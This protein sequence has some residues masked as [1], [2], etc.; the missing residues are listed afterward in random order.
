MTLRH[1]KIFAAVCEH[2]GVT[3]A[4]EALHITQPAISRTIAELEKYYN[5]VLFE[6]INQRLVLTEVGR[7]V[8]GKAREIVKDFEGFEELALRGGNNPKVR[9]GCSL[10]L[11]QTVIPRF[12]KRLQEE[13]T[14]IEPSIVIKA[15]AALEN[16]LENGM[17]DFALVESEFSSPYLLATPYRK[18]RIVAVAS[19]D[20]AVPDS[21]IPEELL[22]YPLLLRER[23]SASRELLERCLSKYHLHPTPIIESVNNQAIVAAV[24]AALGIAFLP[25]SFV[26]GHIERKK[27]KEI[28]IE[29][30]DGNR[31][32]YLVIHKNK[33]L[34]S[35]QKTAYEVLK[36]CNNKST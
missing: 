36:K 8:L 34:T 30:F 32:N 21:L 22:C 23:G 26:I 5:I 10:T 24:Y 13:Y 2:G 7:E 1:L 14:H 20:F 31:S 11:G 12:V 16:E 29:G 17:L 15:S 27:F 25:E 4:A 9:V 3:R 18:D 19:L 28:R 35:A 33:K 6:R